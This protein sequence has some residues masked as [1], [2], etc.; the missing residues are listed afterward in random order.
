MSEISNHTQKLLFA[1]G[2]SSKDLCASVNDNTNVPFKQGSTWCV[3]TRQAN[4]KGTKSINFETC[5]WSCYTEEK[6]TS[7]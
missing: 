3:M 7:G 2:F 6:G 4:I 1:Y 5:N